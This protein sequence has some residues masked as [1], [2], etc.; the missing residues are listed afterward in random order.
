MITANI[1]WHHTDT[2]RD[3]TLFILFKVVKARE[4]WHSSKSTVTDSNLQQPLAFEL[5]KQV[6]VDK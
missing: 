1:E 4:R 6:S 2:G 5:R 3:I